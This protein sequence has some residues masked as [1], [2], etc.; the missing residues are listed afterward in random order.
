MRI[1]E[2]ELK[3]NIVDNIMNKLIKKAQVCEALVV[4]K[5]KKEL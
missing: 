3:L 2:I 1:D 5:L 4:V